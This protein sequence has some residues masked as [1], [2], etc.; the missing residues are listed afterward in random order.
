[1]KINEGCWNLIGYSSVSSN[2]ILSLDNQ[3][4]IE[5]ELYGKSNN[6]NSDFPIEFIVP[7]LIENNICNQLRV[8]NY[9]VNS[10]SFYFSQSVTFNLSDYVGV[11]LVKIL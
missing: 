5:C 8:M 1:M 7:L 4:D 3:I 11:C 10:N 2:K 6:G 9:Y